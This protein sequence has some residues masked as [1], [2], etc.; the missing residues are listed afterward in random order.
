MFKK[1]GRTAAIILVGSSV[2]NSIRDKV[3]KEAFKITNLALGAV[4][5][6]IACLLAKNDGPN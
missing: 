2:V 3:N 6:G 1:I 5:I 4:G